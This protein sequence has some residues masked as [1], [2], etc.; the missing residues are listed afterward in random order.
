MMSDQDLRQLIGLLGPLSKLVILAA[1]VV[2]TNPVLAND[3][4]SARDHERDLNY[5]EAVVE[6]R[7]E[8]KQIE[9]TEGEYSLLLYPKLF[10]LARSLQKI[11]EY[12]QATDSARRAQHIS[13]RHEGVHNTKQLDVINLITQ[14]HLQQA[15]PL[16]ADKQQKFAYYVRKSNVE[17]DSLELLP[18]LEELSNWYEQTG[19]LHRARKLHEQS[20]EIVETHFGP[21][22][23]EQ[24]PY[25]QKLAKLKRLQRVCCSTRI[26][27]E[28]LAVVEANPDVDDE[29]KAQ[30]YVELADAY[31]ISGDDKK[32]N[33]FYRNAWALMSN[34]EREEQFSSPTKIAFSRPLNALGSSSMRVY[35]AERDTF[36]SREFRPI[37]ED[38]QR[39]LDSLP[40][41]EFHLNPDNNVYDVRIRDRALAGD[42]DRDPALRTIGQPYAFSY[43]QFVHLIPARLRTDEALKQMSVELE[44]DIDE[45]GRPHN[46]QVV[47]DSAPG[48]VAN[49]MRQVVR[50]SRF[51]PRMVDGIP[52]ATSQ[53]RLNQSFSVKPIAVEPIAAEPIAAEPIAAEPMAIKR[54]T[55]S[56]ST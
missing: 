23:T 24:L 38:E 42:L 22:T 2:P 44:F 49:L 31:T 20:I 55:N 32:A 35:R 7:S 36:A 33:N 51:R 40:P 41:Q 37:L 54:P 21:E 34:V 1:M 15:E 14:I 50:K 45:T 30:T 3:A 18:A 39:T 10:G 8:I 11:G 46:V 53:Y 9:I 5:A 16:K 17:P 43:N 19:Q 28:A 4:L 26:M 6:Y 13:H 29:L 47:S 48:K 52:I 56:E 25:L 12:E 27:T